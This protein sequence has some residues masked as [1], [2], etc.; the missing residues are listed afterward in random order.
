MN[1]SRST[2]ALFMENIASTLP[3]IET[4]QQKKQVKGGQLHVIPE[5]KYSLKF[6]PS[7]IANQTR[8]TAA[9]RQLKL[10]NELQRESQKLL[11][12]KNMLSGSQMS[13]DSLTPQNK[14]LNAHLTP[15]K[16]S[17]KLLQ[18]VDSISKFTGTFNFKNTKS[19][20]SRN[21]FTD[22]LKHQTETT[23]TRTLKQ[24][25]LKAPK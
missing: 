9:G 12:I 18:K 7:S 15:P 1:K 19:K 16:K 20:D 21:Y 6:R 22:L 14:T 2:L 3:P 24:I 4:L 25:K 13:R 8:K 11:N 10:V 23:K 17:Q 5:N